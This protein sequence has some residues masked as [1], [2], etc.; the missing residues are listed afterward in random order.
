MT[1]ISRDTIT[2]N[3]LRDFFLERSNYLFSEVCGRGSDG[4]AVPV[5]KATQ[6]RDRKDKLRAWKPCK[7][8]TNIQKLP[9]ETQRFHASQSITV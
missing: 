1:P 6:V 3:R 2:E 8:N 5:Y 9:E 7:T 4:R